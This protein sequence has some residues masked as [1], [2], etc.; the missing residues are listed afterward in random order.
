VRSH[1]M[2]FCHPGPDHPVPLLRGC[3]R[4]DAEARRFPRSMV[5]L[6]ASDS[7]FRRANPLQ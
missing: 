6:K 2:P 1:A 5:S 4:Q 7:E 3:K